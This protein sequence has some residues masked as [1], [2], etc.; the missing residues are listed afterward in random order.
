MDNNIKSEYNSKKLNEFIKEIKYKNRNPIDNSV[1]DL[2]RII[3]TN[4]ELYLYPCECLYR[5]RIIHK[6]DKIDSKS[7]FFWI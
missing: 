2:L 5:S 7:P 6:R 3:E 1:L 4:P